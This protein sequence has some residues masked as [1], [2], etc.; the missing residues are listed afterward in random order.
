MLGAVLIHPDHKE[1]IPL[2]PEPI[3]KG[4]GDTKNDCERNAA[5]RLLLDLRKEHPHLKLLIVEDGLSSNFPNLSLI[6]SL[7]MNYIVA[8]KPGDHEYLFDY[9]KHEKPHIVNKEDSDG[10]RHEF[11]CYTNVPLNDAHN[12]YRVNVVVYYETKKSGKNQNFSLATKLAVSSENVYDIMKAGRARW[13]IENETF[14]TLK[15][16]GYHF[17]HNY[18]HGYNNLCSVMT[19]LMMLAFL[20]DQVQQLCCAVYQKARK[21]VGPLSLLFEEVRVLIKFGVWDSW[22]RLYHFIGSPDERGDPG[23]QGWINQY[24]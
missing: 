23:G 2:A 4:D 12:D 5:K 20:I 15:N 10:T 7:N 8:V 24:Q 19:M 6:D 21:H 9:I 14:N 18:G 22:S 13:K 3:V 16:Q 1:V 17:E 11:R